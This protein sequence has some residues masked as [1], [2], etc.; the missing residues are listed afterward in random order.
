MSDEEKFYDR[1]YEAWM[2][3]RNPDLVDREQWDWL[4][5]EGYQP[6]EIPLKVIMP[7]EREPLR[8]EEN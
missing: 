7:P 6:E 3:G 5:A 2:R 8:E 1:V 4:R